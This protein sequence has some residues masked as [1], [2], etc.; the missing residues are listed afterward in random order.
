VATKQELIQRITDEIR[1]YQ[2][3]N[4]TIDE[5][6]TTRLG[7]NRTDGRCVDILE[8]SGPMTAG[9]L[10]KLTGLTTGAITA[11]LDRLEK[12]GLARRVPDP[13]DRRKVLVELTELGRASCAA[14]YGPLVARGLKEM[15][16]YSVTELE[17]ILDFLER[18][19]SLAVDHA[20]RVRAEDPLAPL[21][22]E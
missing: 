4:D 21:L 11:A 5:L 15:N 17:V 16:R 19:H 13:H 2:R 8:E 20:E 1:A 10:A 12:T 18:C 22:S 14:I 6:A 7:L 9:L 3:A